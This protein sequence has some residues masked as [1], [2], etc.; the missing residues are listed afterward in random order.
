[1][2]KAII[3]GGGIGGLAAAIALRQI[4]HE[5]EVFERT[6]VLEEV[7]AGIGLWANG[8]RVLEALEVDGFRACSIGEEKTCV[9]TASGEPLS[10]T[11]KS[12]LASPS[13][14]IRQDLVRFFHRAELLDC[15]QDALPASVLHLGKQ[16]TGYTEAH[17]NVAV[18]FDDGTVARGTYLVGA[19]GIHSAIRAQLHGQRPPRYA[20]YTAWRSVIPFAGR[21]LTGEYWGH[22]ARFGIFSLSRDRVYW[23]A[24]HSEAPGQQAPFG[25]RALLLEKFRGW[26]PGVTTL[27][28]SSAEEDIL[29]NDVVDRPPVTAWG[30]GLATLL[31]D[32]AHPMTPNMGQGACQALE[33]AFALQEAFLQTK[34]VEEALR[35]YEQSRQKRANWFVRQSWQVGRFA[36]S[37]SRWMVSLRNTLARKLPAFV[38]NR[39]LRYMLGSDPVHN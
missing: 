9:R 6:P 31:G 25:E 3:I 5:V 11:T 20:G 32:A 12:L 26:H 37:K 33:D 21:V 18:S 13:F 39:Q 36:Q 7:G 29:R 28:E 38:K 34:Y 1:M 4:G 2:P 30:R 19:D 8:L 16:C 23:F 14:P 24:T 27:I 35:H 22:G 15:L 10:C 17:D